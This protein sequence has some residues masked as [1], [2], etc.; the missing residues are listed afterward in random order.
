MEKTITII[1]SN[2]QLCEYEG[3]ATGVFHPVTTYMN[4][5]EYDSV[6]TEQQLTDGSIWPI[7]ICLDI[8]GSQ[9]DLLESGMV[10][11]LRDKEEILLAEMRVS[12]IWKIDKQHEALNVY[13]TDDHAHPGVDYLF[14]QVKSHYIGGELMIKSLPM[15]YDF[16]QYR[17]TPEESKNIAKDFF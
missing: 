17:I 8:S 5:S 9:A 11:E 16:Q 7:P 6:L 10:I 1:L 2:R 3:I 15:H 13:G 4:K 12:D 14:N